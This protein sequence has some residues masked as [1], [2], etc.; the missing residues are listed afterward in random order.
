MS[1]PQI[2]TRTAGPA[3]EPVTLA[4]ARDHCEIIATDTTHDTKLNRFL[5]AAREK[6]EDDS[7]MACVTQTYTVSMTEFPVDGV[8]DIAIR[9]IQSI[10]SITYYDSADA[11]QTLAT[12]E[13]VLDTQRREVRLAYNKSWPVITPRHN[14]I[15]ITLQAGFGTAANVPAIMKQAILLLT[16]N[17]F[18]NRDMTQNSVIQKQVDYQ[19]LLN[20]LRRSTYP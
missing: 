6:L 2:L 18:A 10:T 16:G 13:Y 19:L 3:S 12:T 15:V 20:N 5:Q 11:Q 17:A 1:L 7:G 8:V 9:P 14:G 4:E